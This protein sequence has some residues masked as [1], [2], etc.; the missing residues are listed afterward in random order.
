MNSDG[1]G[2]LMASAILKFLG[3]GVF[4]A[5]DV[6]AYRSFTPPKPNCA[7]YTCDKYK[8][9]AQELR[10]DIQNEDRALRDMDEQLFSHSLCFFT[11]E[12]RP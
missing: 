3:A 5:I 1:I 11:D 2:F 8:K 9:Y 6:R 10:A 12:S 7:T 4:P